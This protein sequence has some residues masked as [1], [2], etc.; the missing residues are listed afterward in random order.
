[1]VPV[2]DE[3]AGPEAH[4][5]QQEIKTSGDVGALM[6]MRRYMTEGEFEAFR[7]ETVEASS[8]LQRKQIERQF[9]LADQNYRIALSATI[10]AMEK[11][12]TAK[13]KELAKTG[14][15]VTEEEAEAMRKIAD[16]RKKMESVGGVGLDQAQIDTETLARELEHIKD[17]T[18]MT[19]NEVYAAQIG[20]VRDSEQAYL[21][22]QDNL[23]QIKS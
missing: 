3:T 17:A 20:K 13:Q 8:P 2:L 11:L 1:M 22:F 5:A 14:A 6:K 19:T 12:L 7:H 21:K 18:M 23:P 16:Y 10:D 15:K 9:E 4:D